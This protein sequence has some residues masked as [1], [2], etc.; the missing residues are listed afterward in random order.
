[1]AT[2]SSDTLADLSLTVDSGE[3]L[4]LVFVFGPGY[5]VSDG[6]AEIEQTIGVGRR[7]V[8]HRVDLRGP[9]VAETIA[10]ADDPRPLVLVCGLERMAP[11]LQSQ[12]LESMNLLRDTLSKQPAV[13]VM[14]VPVE[15]ADEFRRVC[16]DLFQWRTLSMFVDATSDEV[17]R[18][19]HAYLVSLASNQATLPE[20]SGRFVAVDGQKRRTIEGWLAEVH[21]GLLLGPPGAGK[22]TELRRHAARLASAL[23]DGDSSVELPVFV[24]ARQLRSLEELVAGG[25]ARLLMVD[26]LDELPPHERAS[27]EEQLLALS[28]RRPDLRVI[29][30]TRDLA[31][32]GWRGWERARIEPLDADAIAARLRA[33]GLNSQRLLPML[34]GPIA[35]LAQNPLSLE[36]LTELLLRHEG[37]PSFRI[38]ELLG[39]IVGERVGGWDARRGVVRSIRDSAKL[40]LRLL[41][42]MAGEMIRE[43]RVAL[44]SKTVQELAAT[45]IDPPSANLFERLQPGIERSGLVISSAAGHAFV[46]DSFRDYFAGLWLLDNHLEQE[47]NLAVDPDW[48]W[49]VV[50]AL[51]VLP[52]T[53]LELAFEQLWRRADTLSPPQRWIVR[54]VALEGALQTSSPRLRMQLLDR[55]FEAIEQ[56]RRDAEPSELWTPVAELLDSWDYPC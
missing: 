3:R 28:E 20:G 17:R 49:P 43:H 29:V 35:E 53:E 10:E 14:W 38:T 27:F 26:G 23:L 34:S 54:R 21:R 55:G 46:H 7:V 6:L 4:T 15:I 37:L 56:A 22:T 8:R 25:S 12:L 45:L 47:P 52:N 50:H 16:V 2:F 30:S 39:M 19:H 11:G 41:T 48:Q 32:P 13:V 31:D 24:E 1:V 36:L 9:N 5:L 44:D 51:A 18:A 42:E 33:L 40:L